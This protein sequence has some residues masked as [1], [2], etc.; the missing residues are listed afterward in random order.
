MTSKLMLDTGVIARICHPTQFRPARDWLRSILDRGADAP[1]LLVS[2]LA[3]YELRRKLLDLDA[4][5]SLLHLDELARTLR[6]VPLTAE[7]GR[8]AAELRHALGKDGASG[9]SDADLLMVAQ[10]EIE[11]ASLVTNDRAILRIPGIMAQD[12]GEIGRP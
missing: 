11:G 7:A 5:E 12:W 4:K 3:D 1:E 9:L 8:R 2:V 10:A 6:Y